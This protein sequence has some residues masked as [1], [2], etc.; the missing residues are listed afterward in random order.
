VL[1]IQEM[2]TYAIV[3]A[4]LIKV[5]IIN[6]YA[7]NKKLKK[8]LTHQIYVNIVIPVVILANVHLEIVL[9]VVHNASRLHF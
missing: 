5:I 7:K 9:Q 1:I 4:L 2:V 6:I 3:T 8:L